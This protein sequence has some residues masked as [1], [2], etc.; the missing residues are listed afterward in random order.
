[1]IGEERRRLEE[2]QERL[3]REGQRLEAE[4]RRLEEEKKNLHS[5]RRK[6]ATGTEEGRLLVA[7]DGGGGVG[8]DTNTL[9]LKGA[10]QNEL[11][12]RAAKQ[13]APP[14]PGEGGMDGGGKKKPNKALANLKNDKHDALMAEFKK[15]HKKMFNSSTDE[16]EGAE[17]D[18]EEESTDD[19][20]RERDRDNVT[21]S[22]SEDV[23]LNVSNSS[24]STDDSGTADNNTVNTATTSD[25]GN[26]TCSSSSSSSSP[27]A[28]VS[29][30]K[31]PPPPPPERTSS[32][33]PPG[34]LQ[35]R[36]LSVFK[37]AG[38]SLTKHALLG[39]AAAS[40][41]SSTPGIPTP[42]YD[43]TPERSPRTY[44]YVPI[45][46]QPS[47]LAS[48]LLYC[49]ISFRSRKK[50][51]G[52][53]STGSRYH[54]KS[55]GKHH[56]PQHP[57]HQSGDGG[58]QKHRHGMLRLSNSMSSLVAMDFSDFGPAEVAEDGERPPGGGG[59]RHQLPSSRSTSDLTKSN[60]SPALSSS[61]SSPAG[62]ANR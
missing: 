41:I 37:P 20:G 19:S 21:A 16:E 4:R 40:S 61:S 3:R 27:R 53:H 18:E 8:A 42:D 55:R 22:T 38:E 58:K 48:V 32:I 51:S 34:T 57:Q 39:K 5:G 56:H 33:T 12:R 35:K 44:R 50:N 14:A 29:K 52:T 54:S 26:N 31:V 13:K 30:P 25:V 17:D 49:I 45:S 23:S 10:I 2:E 43:S 1:M 11:Q 7:S 62:E 47:H 36:P 46:A 59:K 6:S 28:Q 24:S 60:P 9:T 15:A